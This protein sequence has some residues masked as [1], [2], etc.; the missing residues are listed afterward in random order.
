M[1]LNTIL[2]LYFV[3]KAKIPMGVENEVKA[4]LLDS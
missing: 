4:I 2:D 1:E 3:M